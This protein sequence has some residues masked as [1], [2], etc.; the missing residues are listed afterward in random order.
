[1]D[2]LSAAKYFLSKSDVEEGVFVTHLKLQKLVYYAQAWHLAIYNKPFFEGKFEA[3]A[4]GP[5]NPELYEEYK[6]HGARPIESPEDFN[7]KLYSKSEKEHLEDVWDVYG[8]FDG[9]YL[10]GLTHQEEPWLEARG[11]LPEGHRCNTEISQE[12][13]KSY[14]QELLV[15]GEE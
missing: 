9:K 15:D 14:Y 2:V 10:E 12:T 3:W 4:H 1:M 6:V 8:K 7:S 13:M 5:V 11:D